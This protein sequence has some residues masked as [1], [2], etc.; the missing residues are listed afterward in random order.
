MRYEAWAPTSLVEHVS[1][2]HGYAFKG[3]Y[4][5]DLPTH[6]ILVTPGNF[7]VGGGFKGD[8]PKY[9]AGE[10]P[11]DYVLNSGDLIITMTDLSKNGDTLGYPALVPEGNDR[12]YLHNQ[13]IGRVFRE[14]ERVSMEFLYWRLRSIDYQRYVVNGASG[15]TVKHTSPSSIVK[16]HFL[17]PP[18]REQR[19]I[20]ATLSCLDDKIELN[21][22]MN[23]NLEEMAQALFKSWFVDFDP[24][25]AKMEGREPA[26]MDAE[27]AALFPDE[28][29]DS[30]LGPIPKGWRVGVLG[31]ATAAQRV[32]F[33]LSDI[34]GNYPYVGLEHIGRKHLMLESWGSASEVS[35][36][37]SAF[38]RGNI[39]FGK[40]RPYFHKVA[41]APVDGICSTDILVFDSNDDWYCYSLGHLFSSELVDYATRLSQGTR[42]PGVSLR[43]IVG[44]KVALPR[45]GVAATFSRLTSPLVSQM[46][47]N[48]SESKTL[49]TLRDTLL[50]KLMSGEIRVPEAEDILEEVL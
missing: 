12:R 47:F 34:G 20:A 13:R 10:C 5:S 8:K 31:E 11:E 24:V 30:E 38:R 36:Q 18:L 2:K 27:T 41:I 14:S 16:F 6:D 45:I 42:M 9:Y 48:A 50:P 19:S 37:K 26:G 3:Q 44:Y 43:D 25:K 46:L 1:I 15:T 33:I 17:L 35:S 21:N 28:F 49:A 32:N 22:R 29:E 23:K 4:F 40:L 7:R 39:L